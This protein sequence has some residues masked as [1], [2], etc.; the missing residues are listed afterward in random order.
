MNIKILS[1]DIE[2]SP[3][4]AH[5]WGLFNQNIG[6]NQLMK[7][8]DTMCFAAKWYDKP[9]IIFYAQ[10]DEISKRKM[11]HKAWT[12][13]DEA[14]AVLHYN[15]IK[16]DIPTLNKEFLLMGLNPPSPFK[17]IDLYREVKK[18]FRLPSYKLDFVA[19]YFGIGAKV[20]HE[21]H[22]LWVK[23]LQNDQDAWARMQKYNEE[24]VLL[25]EKLYNKIKPWVKQHP[26]LGLYIDSD[27]PICRICGCTNLIKKGKEYTQVSSYQR[28]KCGSCGTNL[29]GRLN[30]ADR[31]NLTIGV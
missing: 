23:C 29:R 10:T 28:Y 2:C 25:L 30:E 12:L 18:N 13:L 4:D 20:K 21:G 9:D 11:V 1:I 19:Q 17:Q 16:F 14:D 8:S 5:V 6:I 31:E 24:D 7:P 3:N 27:K 15:G 22:E 26:N